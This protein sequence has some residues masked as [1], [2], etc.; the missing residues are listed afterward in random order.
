M[1]C[2]RCDLRWTF[3][4]EFSPLLVRRTRV[5]PRCGWVSARPANLSHVACIFLALGVVSDEKWI[6]RAALVGLVMCVSQVIA[7]CGAP[8]GGS[9]RRDASR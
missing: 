2:R 4:E 9:P 6:F 5:C 1:N 3:S 7:H 8:A